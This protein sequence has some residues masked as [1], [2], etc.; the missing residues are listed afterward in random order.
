MC[1][2]GKQSSQECVGSPGTGAEGGGCK[3]TPVPSLNPE[4][5]LQP[6]FHSFL[7]SLKKQTKLICVPACNVWELILLLHLV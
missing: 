1:V 6:L 4:P 7:L 5:F 2:P 3:L